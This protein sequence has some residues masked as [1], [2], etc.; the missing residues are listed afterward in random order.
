MLSSKV[1]FSTQF[2]RAIPWGKLE[3]SASLKG[4][5]V[6]PLGLHLIGFKPALRFSHYITLPEDFGKYCRE[7]NPQRTKKQILIWYFHSNCLTGALLQQLCLYSIPWLSVLLKYTAMGLVNGN[8]NSEDKPLHLFLLQ[9]S[10]KKLKY[11]GNLICFESIRM[12][13]SCR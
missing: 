6:M 1:T 10:L 5:M 7:L 13:Q 11:L 12:S 2:I 3:L 4:S 8:T 9:D